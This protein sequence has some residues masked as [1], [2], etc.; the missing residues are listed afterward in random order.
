MKLVDIRLMVLLGLLII[1]ASTRADTEKA[2]PII[3][4]SCDKENSQLKIKNEVK[5]GEAGKNFPFSAEQGTYNPWDLIKKDDRGERILLSESARLN[6]SCRLLAA[7]YRVVV[8]PK[9]F[10]VNMKGKCGDR[11]SVIVSIYENDVLKLE[12]KP[13]ETFCFGNSPVVRG[14]KINGMT[15]KLKVYEVP[16][17]RFY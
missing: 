9:I 16:R 3:T 4:F 8:R 7:E 2:W 17:S 5:W 13:F 6:L 10:N 12:E 1:T 15:G 11:L 14:I